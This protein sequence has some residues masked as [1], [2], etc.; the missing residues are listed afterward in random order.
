MDTKSKV[1]IALVFI[2]MGISIAFTFFRT[3]VAKDYPVIE[4]AK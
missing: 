1:L 4:A 2:L 3:M